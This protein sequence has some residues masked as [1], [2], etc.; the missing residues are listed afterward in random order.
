MEQE[1]KKITNEL[2][3]INNI[4]AVILYGSYA[5][6]NANKKSDIDIC[7]VLKT[8]DNRIIKDVYK[9]TLYISGMSEKYDIKIFENMP[10][11]LKI[12]VIKKSK[13]LSCKNNQ[14]LEEYFYF[15]N[16]LWKD[17]AI[18]WLEKKGLK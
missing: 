11:S 8:E 16:K 14:E 2:E 6:G 15:I 17:N 1:I 4:F 9:K 5:N 13:I 12:E 10:L 18:N 3:K 7:L